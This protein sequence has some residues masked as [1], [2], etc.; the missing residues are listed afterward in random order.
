MVLSPQG[1]SSHL[2]H[3]CFALEFPSGNS[4]EEEVAPSSLF[5]DFWVYILIIN[6]TNILELLLSLYIIK[7]E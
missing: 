5:L 4:N 3:R 1:K 6:S 2:P 7:A